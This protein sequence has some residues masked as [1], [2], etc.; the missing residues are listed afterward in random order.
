M[1]KRH[2]FQDKILFVTPTKLERVA[3]GS[4]SRCFE[5]L[6]TGIG[7][8][9]MALSISERLST[10]KRPELMILFGL[11]GLYKEARGHV[12]LGDV[13]VSEKEIFGDLGRC[14]NDFIPIEVP[15][16][17]VELTIPAYDPWSIPFLGNRLKALSPAQGPMVTVMCSSGSP[18]RASLLFDRFGALVENMEGAAFFLAAKRFNVPFIEVRAMSNYAGDPNKKN[19]KI[20]KAIRSLKVFLE[21]LFRET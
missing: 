20:E 4:L 12:T 18:S 14:S 11:G 13:I 8:V 5:C 9:N 1:T 10:R 2:L 21:E 6:I 3:M 16:E 15:D 19:W 17:P 7:P